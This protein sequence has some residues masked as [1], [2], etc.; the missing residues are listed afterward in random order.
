MKTRKRLMSLITCVLAYVLVIT[1]CSNG[2]NSNGNSNSGSDSYSQGNSK[3]EISVIWPENPVPYESPTYRDQLLMEKFNVV[4]DTEYVSELDDDKINLMFASGKYPDVFVSMRSVQSN[5]WGMSGYLLPIGDYIDKLPNYRNLFTDEEWEQLLVYNSAADGKLYFLP[6]KNPRKMAR[7][8]I[9]RKDIFDSLGLNTPTTADELYDTLKALKAAYPESVPMS[10]RWGTGGLLAGFLPMFRVSSG[11]NLDVDANEVLYGPATDKYRELLKFV[12]K[13]YKENLIEKEFATITE[14]QWAEKNVNSKSFIEYQYGDRIGEWEQEMASMPGVVWDFLKEP[15]GANGQ[16]GLVDKE[17]PFFPYGIAI[18]N[19][20]KGEELDKL[21]EIINWF[22]S[23]EGIRF[24]EL[25][26][27]NETYEITSDG[28]KFKDTLKEGGNENGKSLWQDYGF[29]YMIARDPEFYKMNRK[30]LLNLA[31]GDALGQ[32]DGMPLISFT[33]S[34]DDQKIVTSLLTGVEDIK[35]QF[36]EAAIMGVIDIHDDAVW[37][38]Y[39]SDLDKAGLAQL[40]EIYQKS[41]NL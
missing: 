34:E 1:A 11:F 8:W 18:S 2:S 32:F 7:A 41:A 29:N 12:N 6:T 23:P 25:G 37:Y 15:I 17:N 26:V 5:R 27:E 38:K 39:L 28:I 30:S 9:Y 21:F 16:P 20:V 14:A 35:S 40:T 4:W 36:T 31:V 3:I 24:N 10:N 22:A 19:N 33:I 13:L